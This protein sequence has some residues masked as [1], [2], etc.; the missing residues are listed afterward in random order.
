MMSLTRALLV[1]ALLP[2]FLARSR[3]PDRDPSA[4][5]TSTQ[6]TRTNRLI[7][8]TSPYLLQHAHNPVDWY[9]WGPEALEKA[10]RE[11]KPIFLSIGYSAC[12]W[13]HVM[14]HE[15][16]EDEKITAV[17]NRYFV[18]IK[19]DREERP[20]LDTLYMQATLLMN[21]GQGGWPM[22]VWLT[23]DLKPFFAGTYFPPCAKWG[24]PGFKE[25]CEKI[26]Q[27]WEENRDALV[28]S[29]DRLTQAV[30][31][32][33]ATSVE[34]ATLSLEAIDR[35]VQTVAAAFDPQRGGLRSEGNKFPPNM[36]LDLFLRV[37]ARRGST[38]PLSKRLR[39]LTEVSLDRMARGGIYDQLGGGVAR[40]STDPDWHIPH[41]EK[42]LYDQALVSRVYVDAYQLAK[43]SL[44]RRIAAETFDYVLADLQSPEGGFYSTRD[45]D[46]EGEEGKYYV[47]TKDEI[48]GVLGAEDAELFCSFYDVSDVGNWPDPH[49]PGV[50]KNVLHI[51]R[52]LEAVARLNRIAPEELERRLEVARR[53][54]LEA[55]QRR[56]P[57]GLDDKIIV[58][59]NGLMIA[60]LA[61]GGAVLEEPKYVAA[62]ARAASFILDRQCKNGR[63]LRVYRG[64]RTLDAAF[65]TDYAC[66][67]E[68]LL[69]LYEATFEPRWLDQAVA[70]NAAAIR[71]YYDEAHG[72]F[73]FTADDH[74]QLIARTKDLRD[75]ATPSGNSVQ[76][77]NLLRLSVM[78]GDEKL[79][80]LA[81]TTMQ[82]F[83]ADVLQ[84]PGSNDRFLASAEF[85][86]LGPVELAVVGD[87]ADPRTRGLLRVIHGT[88]LPHR[89]LMLMNPPRPTDNPKSPLLE[90]RSLVQGRAAVYVCRNYVCQ[91]PATTPEELAAQL[92]PNP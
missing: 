80:T 7:H 85:A 69:E 70:L 37:A 58:E 86:L 78:L 28:A 39:E 48:V 41:F 62:A 77:M 40:Y 68:G 46:S 57:P 50:P 74:E 38:D 34:S 29:A 42:M 44:Y 87:P 4:M 53:K 2:P 67:I 54:L 9:A 72:G 84:A 25:L 81:D 6:F 60:S 30:R 76:L 18:N 24:R 71:H 43:K 26:G 56:V 88:Y 22:S 8:A 89:V 33:L 3:A 14:A 90:N 32:T 79:R 10:K 63:L 12:H 16:F 51:P 11:N 75:G 23:P 5:T 20:D 47:W 36:T 55:R 1:A 49:A 45:A 13:C 64:G 31:H 35:T 92:R 65:L 83:A 61:R 91:R 19:V 82:L 15:S 21:Q 17:M 73:F 27:A 52:D 59:W 66:L